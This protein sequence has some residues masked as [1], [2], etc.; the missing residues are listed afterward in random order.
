MLQNSAY[1]T[2]AF[3][4]LCNFFSLVC[5]SLSIT[6]RYLKEQFERKKGLFPLT[7]AEASV[8]SLPAPSLWACGKAEYHS[9]G[10]M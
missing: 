10:N 1:V 6:D 4:V 3:A 8:D 7:T 9:G 5:V 2:E